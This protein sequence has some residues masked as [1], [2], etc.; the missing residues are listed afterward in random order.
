[1]VRPY[2]QRMFSYVALFLL[3]CIAFPV[4]AQQGDVISEIRVIGN[5]KIPKETVLARLFT[6]I[7]EPYDPA[8]VER[9]FNS[10]WNTGYFEDVRIEKEDTPKGVILDIF[11]T[12]KP[13]IRDIEYKGLSSVPISD[14]LDRLKKEKVGF[15]QESQYDP[16]KLARVVTVIQQLLGE[17]GHQFAKVTPKIIKIPPASVEVDFIVKEGPTVKVGRISF[18]G[19]QNVSA[20]NLRGAMRNLKPIGIPHSIFLED[21]F[22]KTYDASKLEEDSDRVRVA[23]QDKG[24][25]RAIVGEP[26]THIHNENGLSLITFRPK[27]GKRIDI[28][29]P[30]EEGERYRLG[31]ITFSGNK[32]ITNTKALRAQFATKDGEYF[33]YTATTKGLQNLQKAYGHLGYINMTAVPTPRVDQAKKLVYLDVDIDEGK[34][35]RVSRIE[36]TGNTVTR[37]R[38]IRR[39]LLLEEG[40]VYDST[41]WETSI[42]RLN[43][44]DYF[45]P[46]RVEQDSTTTQDP[47]AGTVSLL[48]KVHEKG[49]NAIGLNGGVSGLSGSFIGLNYQTNN[50]LGLGETL[51][52]QANVGNLS[53]TITLGFTEPYLHNKPITLGFQVFSRKYDYNSSKSYKIASGG[54]NLPAAQSSLVQNY[55]QDTTGVTMSIQY[56]LHRHAFQRVGATYSFDDAS[57]KTFSAASQNLFQTLAF[58]SG[59]QGQNALEGIYTSAISLSYEYNKVGNPYRPRSGDSFSGAIELAGLGGNVRFFRP[60]IVYKHFNAMRGLHP[61]KSGRNVFAERVQLSYVQGFDGNVAPPFNR[62]FQGGEADLR[63]FDIRSGTPYAFIPT[64]VPFQ[65]T[66]PDG[67]GVPRDPSNP[68]LGSITVPIPVYG[69]VSVGGDTSFVNNLEYRIPIAGPVD[70]K[71]FDDFGIDSA[72]RKT[73]L[74]ESPEGISEL[75]SPLY[76]CPVYVNGACTGGVQVPFSTL[77]RP[78][79]GT[80]F[81][82]RDSIGAEVGGMLPIIH[83]PVRV[84]YAYN[85]LRLHNS[86]LGQTLITRGMFPEGGAGDYSYAQAIQLYGSTYELREPS[87]TFRISVG[88]TF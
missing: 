30:I 21:L 56:P 27:T 18:T 59:I 69:I 12:E 88:T 46:L 32:F 11:V 16:T 67:S 29:L 5:R 9:D 54:G 74:R 77:I 81:V 2:W 22:A 4:F 80:N 1:L 25:F 84:Y 82:P 6:R 50:F 26:V 72:I 78:I 34:P 68:S 37:D 28:K 40:S 87:K 79:H 55:N 43:Q 24:Y 48:L 47:D 64:N 66:N 63:G 39:E 53:R 23:L 76:G 36:F 41:A 45:D 31:G 60:V 83:A 42:L 13:T 19:N 61:D 71:L 8:N 49:K 7:G 65:L 20:R 35:F 10:L 14:V 17:H 3:C 85:P 70:F 52:V 51:S 73:Q 86:F 58:R 75:N 44:L 57:V 15:T 38:V 62:I 33:N